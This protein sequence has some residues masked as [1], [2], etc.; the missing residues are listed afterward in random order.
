MQRLKGSKMFLKALR[1][2]WK[3]VNVL[4]GSKSFWKA[5]EAQNVVEWSGNL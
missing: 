4:E 1:I 2:F 5:S 3:T